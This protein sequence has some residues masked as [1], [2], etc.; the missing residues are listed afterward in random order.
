MPNVWRILVSPKTTWLAVKSGGGLADA[1]FTQWLVLFVA[2]ILI[3]QPLS[4]VFRTAGLSSAPDVFTIPQLILLAAALVGF[5]LVLNLIG[6]GLLM[7]AA[8]PLGEH[9]RFITAW[10]CVAFSLMP[11]MLGNLLA[12]LLFAVIKPL[13]DEPAQ[14]V[15]LAI[16]PYS[17]SLATFL[18][19]HF[20]PVTLSW[21][22]ASYV[23]VFSLW[24]FGLLIAGARWMLDIESRKLIWLAVGLVILSVAV[25]IGLWQSVQRLL[26]M[27]PG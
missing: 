17:F 13:S 18:P 2:S 4:E 3:R 12:A 9:P 22:I 23:D 5:T 14:A 7:L 25:I 11:I 24:G 15:A 8:L 27:I 16:R 10:T 26:L 1:L 21:F 20:P 6:A 19:Q